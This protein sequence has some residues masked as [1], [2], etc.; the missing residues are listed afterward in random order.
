[1]NFRFI[2]NFKANR[3]ISLVLNVL[4]LSLI[5]V[6]DKPFR[7]ANLLNANNKLSEDAVGTNSRWVLL[8]AAQVK[9]R[10]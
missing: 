10:I 8:V 1:M 3:L 9:T 6:K 2:F 4:K 5:N 7:A